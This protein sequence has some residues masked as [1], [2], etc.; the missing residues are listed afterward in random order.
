MSKVRSVAVA[1]VF[2]VGCAVGGAAGRFVVP[3]ASAQQVAAGLQRWEYSCFTAEA[4]GGALKKANAAGL[5][6]WELVST[7][8]TNEYG[9]WCFKRPL[10]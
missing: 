6:G 3:P 5:Q 2:L 7:T 9:Y 1:F 10:P 8:S 4:M